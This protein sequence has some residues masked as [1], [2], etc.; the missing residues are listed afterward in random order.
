MVDPYIIHVIILFDIIFA[1][2]VMS[3]HSFILTA[4]LLHLGYSHR[5]V[6]N[7]Y[8]LDVNRQT[9]FWNQKKRFVCLN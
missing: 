1:Y 6:L 8:S 2:E 5:P 9:P 7:G 3:G 4:M